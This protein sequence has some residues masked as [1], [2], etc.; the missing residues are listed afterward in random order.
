[1]KILIVGGGSIGTRHLQNLQTLGVSS[2][3][4]VE[5]APQRRSEL[6]VTTGAEGFATLEAGLE[7]GP[8]AVIIASPS[9]LHITQSIAAAKAGCHLFIEKP[10]S[11]TTDGTTELLTEVEKRGLTTMVGCN[12]RFHPGT[13]T[14]K[15][16]LRDNCLGSLLAARI[17]AGSYLPRWR[18]HQ[19]YRQSY[20]ASPEWGG[21]IL[22]CIHEID[23]AL[24][25][26]GH[27][28]VVGSAYL[29]ATSIGLQTD[30][31][32]EILLSHNSGVLTNVHLNFVQHDYR[33][34][35][36][37]IGSEGTLYWD[38]M[39]GLV[40]VYGSDGTIENTFAQP[41]KWQFN[42]VYVEEIRHFLQA[43]QHGT[44]TINP[45]EGGIAALD[46]ALKVRDKGFID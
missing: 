1:M 24:W 36:Q 6:C 43:I 7:W 38:F 8:Y 25:Y 41:E 19:D 37:V 20:S 45:L 42:Q 28:E 39:D 40:T 46:I 44:S 12:M 35:C 11:H 30:G 5:P 27:A 29:P 13:T 4:L 33:R 16:L 26:F 31:L 10:L 22:D 14:V 9:N 17:Q 2:L 15:R 21:A 32:A 3:A 18:P 23:L 34:T